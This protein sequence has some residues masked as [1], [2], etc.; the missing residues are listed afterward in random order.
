MDSDF[1]LSPELR[2]G[3]RQAKLRFAESGNDDSGKRIARHIPQ[4]RG[5]R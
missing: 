1:R 4:H 5:L 3:W 2:S